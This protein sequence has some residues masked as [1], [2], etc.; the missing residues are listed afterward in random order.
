MMGGHGGD[1]LPKAQ[2]IKDATMAYFI[3]KNKEA[4][5]LFIHYNGAYHSDNYEGINW[6]LKQE[7]PTLKI[8]TVSVLEQDNINSF[9]PD[10]KQKADFIIVVP[11]TMTK[12]Y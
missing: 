12:T 3:L 7:N 11:T 6:Y 2:A 8:I 4:N 5:K 10:E 1:N 9:N